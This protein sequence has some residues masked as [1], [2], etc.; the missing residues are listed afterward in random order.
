MEQLRLR[1]P[2]QSLPNNAMS[3]GLECKETMCVDS[4]GMG[5]G[6]QGRRATCIVERV[7]PGRHS[8]VSPLVL[9]SWLLAPGGERQ[10]QSLSETLSKIPSGHRATHVWVVPI[11]LSLFFRKRTMRRMEREKREIS[12][13][14]YSS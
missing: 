9:G 13:G 2:W 10:G 6:G 8:T 11:S 7:P 5:R 4:L 3:Q 1:I 12:T 14:R